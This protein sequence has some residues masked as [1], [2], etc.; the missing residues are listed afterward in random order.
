LSYSDVVPLS[1]YVQAFLIGLHFDIAT[2]AVIIVPILLLYYIKSR[3]S[4]K[5]QKTYFII[6][7]VFI[8]IFSI[9]DS[10]YY[11]LLGNRFY[12]YAI[13]HLQFLTDHV[14]MLNMGW[15][16]VFVIVAF[17]GIIKISLL[18]YKLQNNQINS[19]KSSYQ[20]GFYKFL[21]QSFLFTADY[22]ITNHKFI[23]P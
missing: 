15:M 22:S 11:Q 10:Q 16:S 23:R 19:V 12:Y 9:A 7:G 17:F 5:I 8:T 18:Y 20:N 14:G 13:T 4:R 6:S 3:I 2:S 1:E 21:A